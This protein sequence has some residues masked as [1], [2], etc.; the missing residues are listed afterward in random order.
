[1]PRSVDVTRIKGKAGFKPTTLANRIP[2]MAKR[3]VSENNT[4]AIAV[5]VGPD[6]SSERSPLDRENDLACAKAVVVTGVFGVALWFAVACIVAW[7]V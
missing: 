5:D 7:Y 2:H 4:I 3:L 6:E 1:M